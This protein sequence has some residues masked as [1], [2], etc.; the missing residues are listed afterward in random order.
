[1]RKGALPLCRITVLGV[2]F[3]NITRCEAV[4]RALALISERA[5]AYAVT[6]NPEIVWDGRTDLSLLK[7]LRDADLVLPDG[8]GV[9]YAAKI[10]R[11][12]L[13][14]RVTGIDFATALMKKMGERQ[15]SVF[16]FGAKPGI[17]EKAAEK[18]SKLCPGLQIAGVSDGY[19]GDDK[20]IKKKINEAKPDL[21]LVCLGSP[22]QELWMWENAGDMDIGLM[23]G[24]GGVLDVFAGAV[25]RAPAVWQKLG[26]EWLYRLIKEPRRIKRTIKLPLFLIAVIWRRLRGN[27]NAR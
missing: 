24:L 9:V 16:L 13:T 18:L 17:A 19:F 10:L 4:E 12:P 20:T 3:D 23:L 8:I 6:P 27:N 7:A 2:G 26:F 21:L 11:T 15:M 25:K 5:A 14:E 1:M 22:K